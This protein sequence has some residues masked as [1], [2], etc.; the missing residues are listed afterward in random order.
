MP[1]KKEISLLPDEQNQGLLSA[2]IIKWAITVGRFVIVFTELIVI[3]AFISRFWLDR[4]NSDLSEITRQQKAI[5]ESTG[6]FE[7]EYSLLQQRLA[8]IKSFYQQQPDYL[9]GINAL[10]ESTPPEITFKNLSVNQDP[11]TKDVNLVL[12]VYAFQET[13]I[14]DF[15]T[16]LLLNPSFSSVSVNTIEKKPKDAKYTINLALIVKKP[17][18]NVTR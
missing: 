10:V 14:V 13:S 8:F 7:K 4:K 15:I 2:R 5:L 18:A 17:T 11:E 9:P 3:S 12:S 6:E 16:N 1:V